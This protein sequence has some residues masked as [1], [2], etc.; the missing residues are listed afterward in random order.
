MPPTGSLLIP[1]YNRAAFVAEAKSYVASLPGGPAVD[2]PAGASFLDYNQDGV[3]DLWVTQHNTDAFELFPD[4]LYRGNGEGGRYLE[5]GSAVDRHPSRIGAGSD[6][7]VHGIG[8]RE[9]QD[10]PSGATERLEH[11]LKH[12]VGSVGRPDVVSGEAVSQ[13]AGQAIAQCGELA[14]GVAVQG[15]RGLGDGRRD[16]RDARR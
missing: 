12:L 11:L 15:R 5:I 8:G 9:A 13:V 16:V 4:R 14:V 10:A 1:A 2:M 7:R 3:L 6:D